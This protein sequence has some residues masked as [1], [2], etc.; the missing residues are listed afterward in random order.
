MIND[1]LTLSDDG[2]SMLMNIEQLRCKPYDDQTGLETRQWCEGATIGF[3]HLIAEQDWPRFKKGIQATEAKIMLVSDLAPR[4]QAVRLAITS[5]L[6]QQQYDALI[7]LVYNIG[8]T[9]FTKS[10]VVKLIN[11]PRAVT[12]YV[13]LESA[14]KAWNKDRGKIVPGLVN[15]R[16][17]E[18]RVF[19][20]GVYSAW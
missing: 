11:D 2:L 19:S 8:R 20:K 14:W 13:T 3:G 6:T 9:A 15:R 18:W 16:A 17:A 5:P 7:L 12:A 10:S 4:E 1:H